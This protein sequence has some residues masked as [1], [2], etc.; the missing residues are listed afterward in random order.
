VKNNAAG[1]MLLCVSCDTLLCLHIQDW[2]EDH[3]E[4]FKHCSD[5]VVEKPMSRKEYSEVR[6]QKILRSALK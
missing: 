6:N 1:N 5:Q 4:T 3:V 2:G